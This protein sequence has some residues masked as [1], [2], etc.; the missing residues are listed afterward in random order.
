M[1]RETC[2]THNL[3]VLQTLNRICI[4]KKVQIFSLYIGVFLYDEGAT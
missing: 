3:N 2:I 1:A 4:I